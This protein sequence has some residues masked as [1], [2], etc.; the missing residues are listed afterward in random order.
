MAREEEGKL[1]KAQED[2]VLLSTDPGQAE[3]GN[4]LPGLAAKE[5]A[6]QARKTSTRCE[7]SKV[8]TAYES[9]TEGGERAESPP[10]QV[11]RASHIRTCII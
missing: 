7:Y 6:L 1:D 11:R 4:P 8:V 3:P 9:P 2:P 10:L 5:E